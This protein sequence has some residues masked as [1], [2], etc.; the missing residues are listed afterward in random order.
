MSI[1]T[2]LT[3]EFSSQAYPMSPINNAWIVSNIP[4]LN[5][6]AFTSAMLISIANTAGLISSNI[7]IASEAPRYVTSCWVNLGAA[8]L[9]LITCAGY[10]GWMRWENRRRD[11]LQGVSGQDYI[12]R[13]VT[14]T[15]DPRFRFCP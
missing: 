7:L 6:R 1:V 9:C 11:R 15:T 10:S 2:I 3:H 14:G 5:A 12:T 13:G 4:N 8:I